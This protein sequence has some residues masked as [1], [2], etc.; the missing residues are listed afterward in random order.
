A[1]WALCTRQMITPATMARSTNAHHHSHNHHLDS[2]YLDHHPPMTVANFKLTFSIRER[3]K[4]WTR[5]SDSHAER[6]FPCAH[7]L[8]AFLHELCVGHQHLVRRSQS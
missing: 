4:I 5:V 7:L 2:I 8:D 1:T 6:V 3:S